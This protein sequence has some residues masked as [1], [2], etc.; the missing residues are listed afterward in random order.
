M[1]IEI[2]SRENDRVMVFV[3]DTTRDSISGDGMMRVWKEL[4]EP[5]L[6][7]NVG[8]TYGGSPVGH[9]YEI[10]GDADKAGSQDTFTVYSD[11]DDANRMATLPKYA[12][13]LTAN[14][15]VKFRSVERT[16]TDNV[17]GTQMRQWFDAGD[18]EQFFKHLPKGVDNLRYWRYLQATKP[19]KPVPKGAKRPKAKEPPVQGEVLLRSYVREIIRG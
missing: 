12:P 1:L 13:N 11:P 6:P 4:I 15:Q 14:G 3:S 16:S 7:S 19:A 17:S 8:V 18:Q 5:I 9:A 2:A 10:I